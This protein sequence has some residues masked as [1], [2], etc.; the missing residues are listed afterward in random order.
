MSFRLTCLT[1]TIA[2]MAGTAS[3]ELVFNRVA[4]FATPDNMAD[5]EDRSAVFLGGQAHEET[6]KRE[7]A[8]FDILHLATHGLLN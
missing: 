4:S 8:N 7:A 3:A 1:S 6:F 2:L 5:G